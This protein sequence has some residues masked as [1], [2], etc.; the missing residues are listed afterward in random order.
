MGF[1]EVMEFKRKTVGH[2]A[3]KDEPKQDK[4]PNLG[5]IPYQGFIEEK[6]RAMFKTSK[7]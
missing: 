5:S 4:T 2:V 6:S 1:I 3:F 7:N